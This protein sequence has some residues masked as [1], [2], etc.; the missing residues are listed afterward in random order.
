MPLM[1][2]LCIF[3]NIYCDEAQTPSDQLKLVITM[4][5][6]AIASPFP[7]RLTLHFHN[8]GQRTLWLYRPALAKKSAN[9][10]SSLIAGGSSIPPSAPTEGATLAIRLESKGNPEVVLGN[11]EV[12][13]TIGL[14]HPKF[15]RLDPGDDFEEKTAIRLTPA[16]VKTSGGGQPAWGRYNFAATYAAHYSNGDSLGKILGADIW[17]GEIKSNVI[18][19]ELRPPAPSALGSIAGNVVG[20]DNIA[21]SRILVSLSDEQERLLDQATTDLDGRFSFIHLPLGTYWITI[22][23]M[24][25][26]EETT[27]FRHLD[28]IPSE[29]SGTIGFLLEPPEIYEPRQELRKPVLIRVT[30]G[31]G[32]PFANAG[33]DITWSSGTV[34]DSVKARTSEDGMAA[35]ELIPGRNYVTVTHKKCPKDDER[36]DVAAGPGIDGFKIVDECS[37]E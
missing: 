3:I 27:V 13:K 26:T 20:P 30:D 21:R 16:T 24:N 11:G 4:E 17:Q 32:V 31:S 36:E 33:L 9:E 5:Q 10:N 37:K 29:P 8:S 14:P 6:Q 12:L 15:I 2:A 23:E 18:E 7:A 25:S 22:R 34:L 35:V 19:V 1:A 28:L